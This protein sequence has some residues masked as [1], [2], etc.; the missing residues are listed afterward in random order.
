VD[1][2]LDRPQHSHCG[3][4][5]FN[6]AVQLGF[7]APFGG[8]CL[9]VHEQ[10]FVEDREFVS[11][12][13]LHQRVGDCL[14][15]EGGM[16]RG[17][18]KKNTEGCDGVDISATC[19]EFNSQGNLKGPRNAV[20]CNVAGWTNRGYLRAK[21]CN[22]TVDQLRV[23][24]ARYHDD[25]PIT[26]ARFGARWKKTGHGVLIKERP[27]AWRMRENTLIPR[28]RNVQNKVPPVAGTLWFL[29]EVV[30]AR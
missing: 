28:P 26:G 6:T 5:S 11:Q 3:P 18:L 19:G 23:V 30:S 16:S 7:Q 2:R 14:R 25:V 15:H 4:C 17:P 20:D 22:Q 8:L 21:I 12:G 24:E 10:D 9:V 1:D 27:P 29:H 13:D